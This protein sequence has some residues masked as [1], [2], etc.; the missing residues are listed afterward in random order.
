MNNGMGPLGSS[1]TLCGW[2]LHRGPT[3]SRVT[4]QGVTV[5]P[6][7]TV[8]RRPRFQ[9]QWLTEDCA[10]KKPF[11]CC[12][13]VDATERPTTTTP[14]P[15]QY[16]PASPDPLHSTV[17]IARYHM[18]HSI[19]QCHPV[20]YNPLHC[21][22]SITQYHL[23]LSTQYHPLHL[24]PISPVLLSVTPRCSIASSDLTTT[25]PET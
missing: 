6:V 19:C 18:I 4:G 13:D 10:L 14:T 2:V 25:C 11:S 16:H 21:P 7:L 22:V 20:S 23:I 3:T 24:A 8:D 17:S 5:P 9:N 15:G 12:R 1:G